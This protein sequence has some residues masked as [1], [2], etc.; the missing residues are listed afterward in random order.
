MRILALSTASPALSLALFDGG[1]L[2]GHRHDIIGRGH[3]EA[4]LP[5]IAALMGDGRADAIIVDLG[6]GSFTGIRIGI[7]A[8]R[9]LG[10]AWGVPVT[11]CTGAALVA[12]RAFAEAPDLALVTVLLDAGRGQVLSQAITAGFDAGAIATV[13]TDA[14][15]ATPGATAGAMAPATAVHHGQPDVAFALHLPAGA[16]DLAPQALYVRPPDAV[17][18]L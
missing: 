8:A 13:T 10:L 9:A 11:G 2:V 15:A 7:A 18:P 6:P 12:A 1:A 16:R 3:A 5:A 14:A 17:L 4:L